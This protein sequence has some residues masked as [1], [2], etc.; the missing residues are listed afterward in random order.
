MSLEKIMA[1][2]KKLKP[3]AQAEVTEDPRETYQ[4]RL[5]RQKKAREELK[6]LT[7]TYR[8]ALLTNTVFILVTG[9]GKD[10]YVK[11]ANET[12]G[13]FK[14][15]PDQFYTDIVGQISPKLY[16]GKESS[17]NVLDVV[18]R[19]LENKAIEVGISGYPMLVFR[20]EFRRVINGRAEFTKLLKQII[21]TQIGTEVVAAQSIKSVLKQAID[22]ELGGKTNCILLPVD[23]LDQDLIAGLRRVSG[24]VA[25]VTVNTESPTGEQVIGALNDLKKQREA[26]SGVV[27][28]VT[29]ET[30]LPEYGT[31]ESVKTD[32]AA[33]LTQE[34]VEE[35]V[36]Q[37]ATAV[38]EELS[39]SI[40]GETK[41]LTAK[42]R[43][44]LEKQKNKES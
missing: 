5:A 27:A 36:E 44:A 38:R 19:V 11:S 41:P 43:K 25:T 42:Q 16:D 24:K 39:T 23:E 12:F 4:G 14:V 40:V 31:E 28:T 8:Q 17:P 6:S 33:V 21:G 13:F 10:A 9:P 32:V 37:V 3:L 18:S 30:K 1:E 15:D 7:E 34:K 26:H 29:L 20:Q 2:I 22:V 35:A